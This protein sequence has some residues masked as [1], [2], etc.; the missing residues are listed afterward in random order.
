M[1]A[2]LIRGIDKSSGKVKHIDEVPNGLK[3]N[4]KCPDENCLEDLIAVNGGE[5]REH[6]FRHSVDTNCLGEQESAL[7][8]MAKQ[9]IA[10]SNELLIQVKEY[11]SYSKSI[12]EKPLEGVIV[13]VQ[14][15]NQDEVIWLVEIAV[16]HFVDNEKLEKLQRL[17]L[18][19]LEIDLKDIDRR[20]KT[21]KLKD[22]VLINLNNREILLRESSDKVVS[23]ENESIFSWT[24]GLLLM[25]WGGCKALKA[26]K[27]GKINRKYGIKPRRRSKH[28]RRPNR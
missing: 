26:Y 19:V 13:D 10:E 14:I 25:I 11:F 20:I 6:H 17:N 23:N 16:T 1:G 5:R 8:L 27:A 18:N 7:H 9:I 3:C 24:I 12:I 15:E 28:S 4:C 22:V 21:E 2:E